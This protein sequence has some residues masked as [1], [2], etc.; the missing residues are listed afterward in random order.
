MHTYKYRLEFTMHI[1]RTGYPT[2]DSLNIG[3]YTTLDGSQTVLC[4]E[5][6][7]ELTVSGIVQRFYQ[8][9]KN[10]Y[11]RA[12]EIV[13]YAIYRPPSRQHEPH[14]RDVLYYTVEWRPIEHR[15]IGK[16]VAPKPYAVFLE[17]GTSKMDARPFMRKSFQDTIGKWLNM[18]IP[19]LVFRGPAE[20]WE[21]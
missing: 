9:M 1:P 16:L 14:L 15:I 11:T 10:W 18:K 13:P 2:Y 19:T 3:A 20:G 6:L 7:A 12:K 17:F 8:E 21:I 5:K 4:A